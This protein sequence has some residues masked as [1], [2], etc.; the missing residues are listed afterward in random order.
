M[1]PEELE[2]LLAGQPTT[3]QSAAPAAAQ[4]V[5]PVAPAAPKAAK[6][7]TAPRTKPVTLETKPVKVKT[8]KAPKVST[9]AAVEPV[10]PPDVDVDITADLQKFH[11][12]ALETPSVPVL[13]RRMPD[14]FRQRANAQGVD[15]D[16]VFDARKKG[17]TFEEVA[18]ANRERGVIGFI[19][20]AERKAE[21]K[22][23]VEQ[24]EKAKLGDA[25]EELKLKASSA[26]NSSIPGMSGY[27]AQGT[28][29]ATKLPEVTKPGEYGYQIAETL[30]RALAQDKVASSIYDRYGRKEL[31]GATVGYIQDRTED[32]AKRTGLRASDPQFDEKLKALRRRATNEVIAYKTIGLWTPVILAKDIAV[33]EGIKDPGFFEALAPNIELVGFDNKRQAIFRQESALGV[34]FRA[35]DIPQEALVGAR[36]ALP[37]ELKVEKSPAMLF[38]L[39]AAVQGV[40]GASKVDLGKIAGAAKRGIMSG[41]SVME[42]ALATTEGAPGPVRAV[43]GLAGLAGSVVFPDMLGGLGSGKDL[44]KGALGARDMRRAQEAATLLKDAGAAYGAGDYVRAAALEKQLR[45]KYV[46]VA[47]ILDNDDAAVA[48]KLR[49][50]NPELRHLDRRL[51]RE[52]SEVL[53]GDSS[54]SAGLSAMHPSLR[55]KEMSTVKNA[56]LKTSLAYVEKYDYIDHLKRASDDV[57]AIKSVQTANPD[58]RMAKHFEDQVDAAMDEA[59]GLDL[60]N[61]VISQADYDALASVMKQSL[62]QLYTD[63]KTWQRALQAAFAANPATAALPTNLR[64][65]VYAKAA[66]RVVRQ[67]DRTMK[68]ADQ[69]EAAVKTNIDSRRLAAE[70]TAERL[71]VEFP[72]ITV[73]PANLYNDVALKTPSGEPVNLTLLG[74]TYLLG[75]RRAQPNAAFD[76]L[77][78]QAAIMDR[79]AHSWAAQNTADPF[80]YFEVAQPDFPIGGAGPEFR[81]GGKPP[82]APKPAAPTPA[83]APVAPVAPVATMPRA[84]PT[85]PPAAP[86]AAVTPPAPAA[87]VPPPAAVTPPAPKP[88]APVPA[89][90]PVSR[91]TPEA[92]AQIA[93]LEDELDAVREAGT[94]ADMV[95]AGEIEMEIENIRQGAP[96]EAPEVPTPAPA[97]TKYFDPYPVPQAGPPPKGYQ[98]L[99]NK[100]NNYERSWT[101]YLSGKDSSEIRA[102]AAERGDIGLLVT[103]Y[104]ASYLPQAAKYPVFAVDNGVFAKEGF[105]PEKFNALI[106]KLDQAPQAV[107][108]KLLY[109]VA[110]DVLIKLPDGKVVGDAKGTL[111]Q[112]KTWGPQIRAKGLPVALVAQ[113]GLED[114]IDEVPWGQFDVLFIGGSD[115]WKVGNLVGEQ[116]VKWDRLFQ[117]FR[118]HG[119]P[120]HMGRV[121][122]PERLSQAA[123]DVGAATVDGTMLAVAPTQMMAKLENMLDRLNKG[124][125]NA[126][127]YIYPETGYFPDTEDMITA[128][129]D[130]RVTSPETLFEAYPGIEPQEAAGFV[131]RAKAERRR[132]W[133]EI[134]ALRDGTNDPALP[135]LQTK[136]LKPTSTEFTPAGAPTPEQVAVEL[137]RAREATAPVPPTPTPAAAP[138]AAEAAPA[139]P[140]ARASAESVAALESKLG[141]NKDLRLYTRAAPE[142]SRIIRELPQEF[143]DNLIRSLDDGSF[144]DWEGMQFKGGQALDVLLGLTRGSDPELTARQLAHGATSEET[145]RNYYDLGYRKLRSSLRSRIEDLPNPVR[146]L[147]SPKKGIIPRVAGLVQYYQFPKDLVQRLGELELDNLADVMLLAQARAKMGERLPDVVREVLDA[148][149]PTKQDVARALLASDQPPKAVVEATGLKQA[150]VKKLAAAVKAEARRPEAAAVP[151]AEAGAKGMVEEADVLSPEQA[152]KEGKA[153]IEVSEEGLKETLGDFLFGPEARDAD[154]PRGWNNPFVPAEKTKVIPRNTPEISQAEANAKIESWKA[155]AQRQGAEGKNSG[156]V[157][158]SLFDASGE[159]SKPWREA[160]YTVFTFD[161]QTG[162]DIR[163]FSA[164]Y[165]ANEFGD[166]GDKVFAILA[167]PPCTNFSG[168]GARWWKGMD[169][170]GETKVGIELVNQTLATVE[171]FKPAVWTLENPVG[172][173]KALTGLPEPTLSFN[174]HNFGNPYTKR[175]LLWG[176]FNPELPLANVFP[177]EGSRIHKLSG[178]DKYGRSL[179]PEGFAYAFFMANNAEALGDAKVI[180]REMRGVPEDLVQKALDAGH[181]PDDIRMNIEDAFYQEQSPDEIAAILEDM[182]ANPV[183]KAEPELPKA[184]AAEV[185]PAPSQD[186]KKLLALAE[187]KTKGYAAWERVYDTIEASSLTSEEKAQVFDVLATTSSDNRV[188]EAS[189][190]DAARRHREAAAR[191]VAEAEPVV[192]APK[193]PAA[194]P[195]ETE[196][197]PKTYYTKYEAPT[198]AQVQ[199]SLADARAEELRSGRAARGERPADLKKWNPDSGESYADWSLRSVAYDLARIDAQ[200]LKVPPDIMDDTHRALA[201]AQE[202]KAEIARLSD[203]EEATQSLTYGELAQIAPPSSALDQAIMRELRVETIVNDIRNGAAGGAAAEPRFTVVNARAVPG[204]RMASLRADDKYIVVDNWKGRAAE[205]IAVRGKPKYYGFKTKAEGEAF[206][207]AEVAEEAA[208]RAEAPADLRQVDPTT[209]QVKGAVGQNQVTGRYVVTLFKNAD[210]STALHE[211]AHILRRTHLDSDQMQS[212]VDYAQTQGISVRHQ[213]G[214][215]IGA[216]D[217]IEKAEELFAQA[218]ERYVIDGVAPDTNVQAAFNRLMTSVASVYQGIQSTPLGAQLDPKMTAL[219]DQVVKGAGRDANQPLL[220]QVVYGQAVAASRPQ[221]EGPLTVVAREA[222]RLG[223]KAGFTTEA[224]AEKLRASLAANNNN[225]KLAKITFPGGAKVFGKNEWTAE[226]LSK[227]GERLA[228]EASEALGRAEGVGIDFGARGG[229][230]TIR[231]L[232]PVERIRSALAA[233]KDASGRPA[234]SA[235][236]AN[237]RATGRVF[238]AT[239]FGGDIVGERG[240]RDAPVEL[241]RDFDA[242]TRN[243]E[244]GIGDT[245]TVLNDVA[246]HGNERELYEFLGGKTAVKL[247]SGRAVFSSG[248]DMTGAVN[249]MIVNLFQSLTNDKRDG[250]LALADAVNT[251]RPGQSIAQVGYKLTAQD[252]G[253]LTASLNRAPT[254]K[255]LGDY[256][257]LKR[258]ELSKKMMEGAHSFLMWES[259]N[260]EIPLMKAIRTA[261]GVPGVVRPDQEY[262]AIEAMLY[263]SGITPRNGAMFS[264]SSANATEILLRRLREIYTSPTQADAGEQVARQVAVLIG[265]YGQADRSKNLLVGL[266]LVVDKETRDAFVDFMNKWQIPAGSRPKVERLLARFGQNT[267]LVS[268]TILGADFYIPTVARERI[269]EALGKAQFT[270]RADTDVMAMTYRYMKTRM[271]RGSIVLRQKY[272]TANTVDHFLQMSVVAGYGPALQSVSRVMAQNIMV[273]PIWQQAVAFIRRTPVGRSIPPDVLEK[274][275]VWLSSKGDQMANAIG[276][277]V[278]SAKYRIEVNPI[279]EGVDGSF[280][281]GDRVYS[282]KELRNIAVEEGIFASLDTRELQNAIL[283]EGQIIMD[284]SGIKQVGPTKQGIIGSYLTPMMEDVRDVSEAWAERERLGAMVT[285]MEQGFD[286]R[287]AARLTIDALYDY[288]QTMTKA[289]RAWW[290]GVVFPFWAFQKNAN[291]A[292]FNLMLSPQGAYRM[293]CIQRARMRGSELLTELL[294]NQVGDD[295]GVDV[296]NMPPELQQSYYAIITKVEQ[297]YPDGVP[298]DVKMA[299]RLLLSGRPADVYGGQEVGVSAAIRTMRESGAFG[300]LDVFAPFVVARPEKSS[301][302]SY[303]RDRPGIAITPERNEMARFYYSL[304]GSNDHSYIELM[305][306]ESFIEAGMRHITYVAAAY[307]L[308]AAKAAGKAGVIPGE[309]GIEETNW[310]TAVSPILD[311]ERSPILGPMLTEL[312]SGALGYPKRI[313]PVLAEPT[314]KAAEMMTKVHP[315]LGKMLDDMFGATF[316]RVPEVGDPIAMAVANGTDIREI[317]EER[318]AEIRA[319]QEKYPEAAMLRRQRYYLPGGTWST[320]FENLP[321]GELNNFL[322]RL[323]QSEMEKLTPSTEMV[324]WARRVLGLDVAEVSGSKTARQEEPTKLKSTKEI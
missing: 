118:D 230:A 101:A 146:E 272:F 156:K 21:W 264:G 106:D 119:V 205:D 180:A 260:G 303:M 135:K 240:M 196:V 234:E 33:T 186:L 292:V 158:L 136:Q 41:A 11:D 154:M 16:S 275:R 4:P 287:V 203:E 34:V 139:A 248:Y 273:L 54:T 157:V 250:L 57:A 324:S 237:V 270:G 322:L 26:D 31:G 61:G 25:G 301:R 241:R 266:G 65:G 278:S 222:N 187:K 105:N 29:E 178:K 103:P 70:L 108:D 229:A 110:P 268:D 17:R 64:Q 299:M 32:L 189:A 134:V 9:P 263:V 259:Q 10:V 132:V 195:A 215:F 243:I 102:K 152:K 193:A 177:T 143:V 145:F 242:A 22:A 98:A 239:F 171:Y 226:E 204:V 228:Q 200:G 188:F 123:H 94:D 67:F 236:A 75:L 308:L 6:A 265:A 13:L 224:L 317:A 296:E 276:A 42:D 170:K 169:A 172:R 211:V 194:A 214:E 121:S 191:L 109:V 95:R 116:K 233:R 323:E 53:G 74:Q 133:N 311:L 3:A 201:D 142:I 219:F 284:S 321:I 73:S 298:L 115:D 35:I 159:W 148:P 28:Q 44:I 164:E 117:A 209:G 56:D 48:E 86:P 182:I 294:Y 91:L 167:A 127:D 220:P 126:A 149:R 283:R 23:T 258:E 14:G 24:F 83:P 43:A 249:R 312:S 129:R 68:L 69:L 318:R 147:L 175:T 161:L 206:V 52:V 80:R 261:L 256:A 160:G 144:S 217:D 310:F 124:G 128:A 174:P 150:E 114:M 88:V 251:A 63:P 207:K 82:P 216:Q 231:E 51:T 166:F 316:V 113:N 190:R 184:P 281:V 60:Q 277:M 185:A 235:T 267:R 62:G 104:T 307:T 15:L 218:F 107:K 7:D 89:A 223:L 254:Q 76:D 181:E 120:I 297:T 66:P 269:A 40:R 46:K 198:L 300:D 257:L 291:Q 306:P 271:T 85:A 71:G 252:I 183:A 1:T 131:L 30:V 192:E 212:L 302:A 99:P 155:E 288:S 179:T 293:M 262:K 100:G 210:P 140:G 8:P 286:P 232:T 111:E 313:S 221:S 45:D 20:P 213:F 309:T 197:A 227:L 137:R 2:K 279:L 77:Y 84:T 87:P 238:A 304:V 125:A 255:E 151:E 138:K 173:I 38:P 247:S 12:L 55:G 19:P 18:R 96:V 5:V 314:L 93:K 141:Q 168:A 112:F 319:L 225:P 122:G 176:D 274:I 244:Q 81:A 97:A 163:K 245:V 165:F 90:A 315:T 47:D 27:I 290:V 162:D 36:Q 72:K 58:P 246:V 289:D 253:D 37:D 208:R 49:V 282:Y 92:E 280:V 130:P 153:P 79:A 320:L 39:G 199:T 295:Y 78:A 285:L 59:F 202:A 50:V 305:L